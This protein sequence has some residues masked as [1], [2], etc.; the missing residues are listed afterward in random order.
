MSE[1][2]EILICIVFISKKYKT[3]FYIKY[4][5][6]IMHAQIGQIKNKER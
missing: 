4:F 5:I 1:V 6:I 3:S 2:S